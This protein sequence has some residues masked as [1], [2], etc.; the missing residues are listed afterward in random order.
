[1]DRHRF[2]WILC[3]AIFALFAVSL[4]AGPPPELVYDG[5]RLS[6][7]ARLLQSDSKE[8]RQ[9]AI[10]ALGALVKQVRAVGPTFSARIL[11]GGRPPDRTDFK[12]LEQLAPVAVPA[13]TG[14]LW[15]DDKLVRFLAVAGLRSLGA[16][17]K[18]AVPSLIERLKDKEQS[19][20]SLAAEALGHTGARSAIPPLTAALQDPGPEVRRAAVTSLLYLNVESETVVPILLGWLKGTEVSRRRLAAAVLGGFG[21]EAVAAV[22]PLT[23]A[24]QDEDS[25]VRSAA[26]HSLG[27]IGPGAR[28]AVAALTTALKTREWPDDGLTLIRALARIGEPSA[29]ELLRPLLKKGNSRQR[30]DT[31]DFL[32]RLAKSPEAIATLRTILQE[33]QI[34]DKLRV[35][36]VLRK[37]GRRA[38]AA[39]P[40]LLA[41]LKTENRDLRFHVCMLLSRFGELGQPAA[42]ELTARLR[43]EDSSVRSVAAFALW[44]TTK[45]G[46]AVEQLARGLQD[47]DAGDRTL[48]ARLLGQVS[49]GARGV[50]PALRQAL[51]DEQAPVRLAVAEALAII[52]KEDASALQPF[53]WRR[54]ACLGPSRG[55]LCRSSGRS[56]STPTITYGFMRPSP[57]G[58]STGTPASRLR[59][60]IW[61]AEL[62]GCA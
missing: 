62:P 58:A 51:K 54:S 11:R 6:E 10:A 49:G 55:R 26:A 48:A 29:A 22:P 16:R 35:T 46:K 1:M 60:P 13:L 40:E 39:L 12:A 57:C 43:D 50:L 42:R 31:A 41:A 17:A 28:G 32:W 2:A 27:D 45:D 36:D 9:R 4:S 21:P 24:L 7:W 19:I 52:D 8:E 56:S 14:A 33:G 20:R 30:I 44:E 53:I 59:M 61:K 47:K 5:K 25:E 18:T 3:L 15:D 34:R 23:Q 38:R 37:I